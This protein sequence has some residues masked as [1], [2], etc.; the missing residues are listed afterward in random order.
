MLK[1]FLRLIVM[2]SLCVSVQVT[3]A[4][5]QTTDEGRAYY[6]A[7]LKTAD[8]AEQVI[9]AKRASTVSLEQLRL[10]LAS[11]RDRFREEQSKNGERIVTLQAQLDALGE[12][13]AEGE[14]EPEDLATLRARL[15]QQLLDLRV[16]RIVSEEAFRRADGLINEVDKI[17][18]DR[19]KTVLLQRGATPLNPENWTDALASLASASYSMWNETAQQVAQETTLRK[20]E[21]NWPTLLVLLAIGGALLLRG[22]AISLK[23]AAYVRRHALQSTA[24]W[25]FCVSL[26]QVILPYAGIVLI[27]TAIKMANLVG[28]RGS[29]LIDGVP[30]WALILLAFHW[31]GGRLYARRDENPL[32]PVDPKNAAATWL[33]VDLLAVILVAKEMLSTLEDFIFFS[34]G[35]LAVVRFPLILMAA[36]L[37]LRLH[38]IGKQQ[39]SDAPDSEGDEGALVVGVNGI[40]QTVRRVAYLFGF[41]SPVLAAAGYINAA[42]A[43]IYPSILTLA[44]IA[45]L[46]VLQRFLV[47]VYGF[48]SKQNRETASDSLVAVLL[49][50]L[51]VLLSAPLFALIWG[52]RQADLLELLNKLRNGFQVGDV[53]ISPTA[54]LS[55]AVIFAIGYM[56]TRIVQS[57]LR[58]SLLP[59]TRLDPGG[60][61]AIV[62][63]TGYIGIFLAAVVAISAAGLDLSSLAIVAGALSVGIGFGLQTI[64]SNFVS[65]IILLIERP[66]SKGD[67]IE[68]GGMMGYVRDISV[69]STRIE[70]F[71]RTDVIVPNSDL[72][73]GTVTNF[74][75]GN[76]VGR[77]IVSVGVAYGT[78]PRLV[79]GILFD[80]ANAHPMVLA[81][82]APSV[83]F[84][85]F[86]A[87]SLD[88]EIRAI[89]RDVNWMLSVKSDINYE[90]EKQFRKK[91]IEIPFAQR[92]LWIR[93]PEALRGASDA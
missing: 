92:D 77:V 31:L 32:F 83:V 29:L 16:P 81:K 22:R 42:E 12:A 70:T 54:F 60:Q 53:S 23:T 21:G 73:T 50:F 91:G 38:R 17:I 37:M 19:R 48:F 20:I 74:T 7:W 25:E 8:R 84:Q 49:G 43:L 33:V 47:D 64:V 52:A 4:A 75:R 76:T 2:V 15:T 79:E 44:L 3:L 27:V 56:V 18:R 14:S 30:R 93:N 57:S 61:N 66:I 9:D 80:I 45:T 89:L 13:P 28:V 41:L 34:E 65:G 82:P 85:G 90:I 72:I 71:D 86:G 1:F 59:K 24:I 10:D 63:G 36:L 40:I 68:V 35:A 55:F 62:S 26:W 6:Q 78:D 5:A 51:L 58:T 39:R 11:Y 87:D 88:F 67:W 69:R 46:L